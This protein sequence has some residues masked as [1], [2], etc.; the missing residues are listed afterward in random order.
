MTWFQEN[1]VFLMMVA[2]VLLLNR[3]I[4]LAR[5][6]RVENIS[7]HDLAARIASDTP[8]LILDV[9]TPMEYAGGHLPNA[10][11]VPLSELR[12]HLEELRG[13][14]PPGGVAVICR[15]GNRSLSA[16]VTLK[17]NGFDKVVN[18]DGGLMKWQR[19]GFQV[20]K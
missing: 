13:K 10:R 11:L 19:Q 6:Y 3:G 7:V 18:V 2:V 12:G 8:P 1:G 5:L 17:Q 16:A 20:S 14:R 15:T 4:I 9:R